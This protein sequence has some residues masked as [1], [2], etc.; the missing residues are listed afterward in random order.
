VSKPRPKMRGHTRSC[1]TKQRFD[2]LE[3]A[4]A[5]SR[6]GRW[7]FMRAYRCLKCKKY[8]YGHPSP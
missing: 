7:N 4:D 2:T 6:R 1:G 3:Q 5:A 8:H